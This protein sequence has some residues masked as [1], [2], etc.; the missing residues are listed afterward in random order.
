MARLE[1]ALRRSYH[2]A[3]S[4]PIA[5]EALALPAEDLVNA[6]LT[7]TP[8]MELVRSPWPIHAIWLFN[9]QDDAP[10]PQPGAQ[11]VLITRA[12]FD[13]LPQLLPAGGAEWIQ[14]MQAGQTLGQAHETALAAAEGFDL[15]ATLTLLLQGNAITSVT[16]ERLEP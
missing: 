14:A 12:E 15:G 10:K 16:I 9:T 7:F 11:D 4:T 3:D 5:P 2:A 1:L 8:S 13:P 6:R